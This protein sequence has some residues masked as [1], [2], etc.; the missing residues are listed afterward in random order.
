MYPFVGM[1]KNRL[2]ILMLFYKSDRLGQICSLENFTNSSKI[3]T[4]S[5]NKQPHKHQNLTHLTIRSEIYF[6]FIHNK[7]HITIG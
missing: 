4:T 5:A 3:F 1:T 2:V 7:R 6:F